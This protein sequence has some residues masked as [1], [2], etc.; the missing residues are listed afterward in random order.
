L[1]IAAVNVKL[2]VALT[3]KLFPPL[4]CNTSPVPERPVA[5][6]PIVKLGTEGV[7]PPPPPFV[8]PAINPKT[9]SAS[10]NGMR[11]Q[12]EQAH[13]EQSITLISL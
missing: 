2:P 5:A 9:M 10:E 8:H 12:G 4:S 7:E 11:V 6:P 13:R 1:A 3:G